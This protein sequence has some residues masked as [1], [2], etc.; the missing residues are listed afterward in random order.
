M[1]LILYTPSVIELAVSD[2][3]A[4]DTRVRQKARFVS[5]FHQQTPEGESSVRIVVCVRL[6]AAAGDD[7]GPALT[8]PGFSSYE[9]TL[10]AD[11]RTLVDARPEHA[12]DVLAIREFGQTQ[13]SWQA[14]VDSFEQPTMLQ[15]DFFEMLRDNQPVQI[16]DIIRQ[17]IMRADALGRFA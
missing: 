6:Y 8:G 3:V 13:A 15:G 12:G 9:A 2:R 16:G 5:L 11:N 1:P 14:V 17:H 10:G 7:Y 4:G